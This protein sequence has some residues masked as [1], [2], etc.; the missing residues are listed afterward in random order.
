MIRYTLAIL[1]AICALV[2]T[3]MAQT[4][5]GSLTPGT[6]SAPDFHELFV[7]DDMLYVRLAKTAAAVD[8]TAGANA[9]CGADADDAKYTYPNLGGHE[10]V[11]T[12]KDGKVKIGGKSAAWKCPP[13]AIE[14]DE[15][16]CLSDESL[17][18][19]Q[20]LRDNLHGFHIADA[21][22]GKTPFPMSHAQSIVDHVCETA[23]RPFYAT[24]FDNHFG[25]DVSKKYFEHSVGGSGQ[26]FG[27][28]IEI[29]NFVYATI[30]KCDAYCGGV[31]WFHHAHPKPKVVVKKKKR[32]AVT[33]APAPTARPAPAVGRTSCINLNGTPCS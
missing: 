26:I 1:A 20:W 3:A 7:D 5:A 19:A 30:E 28:A 15:T 8:L 23:K 6:V 16:A 24:Y 22:H 18:A 17:L 32:A 12:L 13:P 11:M 21:E 10:Y 14:L 4:P 27:W 31:Y 33:P 25:R 2:T 29:E 9:L